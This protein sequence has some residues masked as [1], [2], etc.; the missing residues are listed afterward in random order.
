MIPDRLTY[1]TFTEWVADMGVRAGGGKLLANE[2]QS[3]RNAERN[4]RVLWARRHDG[5]P[6]TRLA[7]RAWIRRLRA[8]KVS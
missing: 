4:F 2:P 5:Y 3:L 7:I 6:Q 8:L 1:E